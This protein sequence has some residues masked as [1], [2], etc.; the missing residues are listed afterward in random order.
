[1][2]HET[3]L[4]R[5]HDHITRRG[6][7]CAVSAPD[8]TWTH[9]ELAEQ[10]AGVHLLLT[11]AA[12]GDGGDGPVLVVCADPVR[13]AVGL[14][15]C[16]V[17]GRT[18]APVDV[19]QPAARWAAIVA[20]LAPGAVVADS[21]G[22]EALAAAGIGDVPVLRAD[23]CAPAPWSAPHLEAP[24]RTDAGY[25]YFTSG[26]TGRPKGIRGSLAAVAHF[27]DWETAEFGVG[28]G[29]R[30]SLL[31]SPGFDAFLRDLLV[32]LCAGGTVCVAPVP[33]LPVGA[34]LVRWLAEERVEVLHCVPTVFRTLRTAGAEAGSL[35]DL[36]VALLAG[37]P[38]RASD[39]AWWRGLFGDTKQLVNLY[40]PSETT[41]TKV[42]RRLDASDASAATVPAGRPMPG[43]TV[44]VLA[45]GAAVTDAIGEVEI[46]V[47]FALSGYLGA[48]QGGFRLPHR[49]RTG[50]LGRMGADGT[51]VLLG[52][53]DQQVKVSGVRIELGAVEEALRSHPSV[54]DA[55][56]V[57]ADHDGTAVLGAYVVTDVPVGDEELR[58]HAALH[59]P[60]GHLPSVVVRLS[61]VPRTLS[62]KVDRRALPPLTAARPTAGQDA[63]RTELERGIAA[64][65]CEL[66]HLPEV[67]RT[68]DF[69]LL[70]GTSLAMA[71]LLD[72]LRGRFGAEV[73]LRTFLLDPTVAGLAAAVTSAR[74]DRPS[75]L[76]EEASA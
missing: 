29:T 55:C 65:W 51:L 33:E 23:T 11:G 8:R 48:D 53:R 54:H 52:R 43:V 28:E 58:A 76:S 39:V 7:A 32:P 14:L 40:G 50:D 71:R 64:L 9:R 5:W 56:A 72:A 26:T 63:P 20:D 37:E 35:P 69:A 59:L 30:V 73:A 25:V 12:A 24:A 75:Q 16:A 60:A 47:P 44:R 1:M 21:A 34:A 46:E 74:G 27:V 41:M 68:D 70:G 57:T 15:A 3:L 13:A 66:L 6:D 2:S 22:A 61:Q 62:G 31:T 49:Y 17:A 38:V 10:V 19:R 42:F 18:A 4:A 36:R 67:G 45:A